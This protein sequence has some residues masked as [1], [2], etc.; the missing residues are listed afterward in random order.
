MS[1]RRS[2]G[3]CS[4]SGLEVA[5][6]RALGRPAFEAD[7]SVVWR[8]LVDAGYEQVP[9]MAS[10]TAAV[11][12]LPAVHRDPFDRSLVAQ[13]AVEGVTLLTEDARLAAYPG[14]VRVVCGFLVVALVCSAMLSSI[15]SI[16]EASWVN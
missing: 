14:P 16:L 6:K 11:A 12:R 7:P 4:G 5:I 3:G 15:D 2:G 10:H 9:V 13:A 1:G 8:G